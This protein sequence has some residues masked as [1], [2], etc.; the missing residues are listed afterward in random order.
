VRESDHPG[1]FAGIES[2]VDDTPAMLRGEIVVSDWAAIQ[3]LPHFAP[4]REWL[5]RNGIRTVIVVPMFLGETYSGALS[6]RFMDDHRLNADEV[7]LAR[8]LANQAVLALEITRL[9]DEAKSAA[10]AVEREKAA[11]EQVT[12]LTRANGYLRKSLEA[13]S[14]LAGFESTLGEIL[15]VIADLF[16]S[17]DVKYWRHAED[18]K[19]AVVELALMRGKMWTHTELARAYP[20]YPGV[21]GYVV[22]LET[23]D[24]EPLHFRTK[25]VV[26][27]D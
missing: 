12:E 11:R 6:L 9:A 1:I 16:E 8:S 10:V 25:H 18:G 7:E 2:R 3:T 23:T 13:S 26:I 5:N 24:L 14:S 27:D 4:Y 20:Q 22:N 15:K 21:T 17:D 19:T